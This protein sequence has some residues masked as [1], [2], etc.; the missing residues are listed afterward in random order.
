ME[1]VGK[2]FSSR[3]DA[4][5]YVSAKYDTGAR[6]FD[7]GCFQI[8]YRWHGENFS[9][10]N[11][12][13]DPEANALYAARFLKRLY[14]EKN[15][16]SEAAGA[17]HSRTKKY[18]TRYRKRFDRILASDAIPVGPSI[19]QGGTR[20]PTIVQ[21][22]ARA[23][24]TSRENNYPFFQ[25]TKGAQRFGSLVPLTSASGSKGSLFA[26]SGG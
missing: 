22:A 19:S 8:N 25:D 23:S 4:L 18:S 1:G 15:D 9:S 11:E 16:W 7:V 21:T 14:A 3:D 2:W 10:I 13:F 12:M 6:S 17:Y 26:M 20:E 24:G 5:G